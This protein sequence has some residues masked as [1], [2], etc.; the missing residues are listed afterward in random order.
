MS[1]VIKRKLANIHSSAEVLPVLA[2]MIAQAGGNPE[3]FCQTALLVLWQLDHVIHHDPAGAVLWHGQVEARQDGLLFCSK[4]MLPAGTSTPQPDKIIDFFGTAIITNSV[5]K[6][7][8]WEIGCNLPLAE[9]QNLGTR[10]G[11][12]SV[13]DEYSWTRYDLY[14]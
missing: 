13:S 8:L 5:Y 9:V 1:S 4:L 14:Y 2:E 6:E 11:G 12:S 7:R 10:G 3:N